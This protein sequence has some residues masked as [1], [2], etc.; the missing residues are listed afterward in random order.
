MAN[1]SDIARLRRM[2]A[3]LAGGSYSD[4]ELSDI[5]DS[6]EAVDKDG[7]FPGSNQWTETYDL[8]AAAVE[9]WEAKAAVVHAQH[10][11]SADGGSYQSSQVYD[12]C[13]DQA[14]YHRARSR[15]TTVRGIKVPKE[16]AFIEFHNPIDDDLST[17]FT[18]S[19]V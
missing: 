1:L 3:E 17:D 12:H 4:E 8:H 15:T 6:Y 9:V 14:R 19:I 10:D 2:T 13:M 18:D 7:N 16:S 5:I 11:F